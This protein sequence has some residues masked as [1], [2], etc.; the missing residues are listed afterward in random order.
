MSPKSFNAGDRVA[1]AAA[2]LK[3]T[4]QHTGEV[5]FMRGTVTEQVD[6]SPDFRLVTVQWD[7]R[8]FSKVLASNLTLVSRIAIDAALA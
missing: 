3:S 7:G 1:F 5:P 6:H 8:G 2:F 4:A